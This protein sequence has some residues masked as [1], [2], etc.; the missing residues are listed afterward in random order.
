M[1][2]NE[3]RRDKMA[4]IGSIYHGSFSRSENEMYNYH[5]RLILKAYVNKI[6]NNNDIKDEDMKVIIR[7]VLN[8][9]DI[10]SLSDKELTNRI[11][12][13]KF[14]SHILVESELNPIVLLD[15]LVA[16][17]DKLKNKFVKS[18]PNF[19]MP[20]NIV[21]SNFKSVL[22]KVKDQQS[23]Y[24]NKLTSISQMNSFSHLEFQS[25][26]YWHFAFEAISYV[27]ISMGSIYLFNK[28]IDGNNNNDDDNDDDHDGALK[29]PQDKRISIYSEEEE[30]KSVSRKRKID[31][32]KLT[33][34]SDEKEE[35]EGEVYNKRKKVD[36]NIIMGI[37]NEYINNNNN[38]D[39]EINAKVEGGGGGDH[40]TL[41]PNNNNNNN[42]N[43][44][45][46]VLVTHDIPVVA[47]V[48]KESRTDVEVDK[49]ENINLYKSGEMMNSNDDEIRIIY[50]TL[51]N[52]DIKTEKDVTENVEIDTI[53]PLAH[54]VVVVGDDDYAGG[55]GEEEEEEKWAYE[56]DIKMENDTAEDV[57]EEEEKENITPVGGY[58]GETDDDD[59][60][61]G[62]GGEAIM[63]ELENLIMTLKDETDVSMKEMVNTTTPPPQSGNQ[64]GVSSGGGGVVDMITVEKED[65][66]MEEEEEEEDDNISE[67]G[68]SSSSSSSGRESNQTPTDIIYP[69]SRLVIDERNDE[70][71]EDILDEGNGYKEKDHDDNDDDFTVKEKS[72]TVDE[73]IID[74]GNRDDDFTKEKDATVD[75][76]FEDGL[77]NV[78]S[79]ARETNTKEADVNNNNERKDM[80]NI[81]TRFWEEYLDTH[82]DIKQR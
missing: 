12:Y 46:N 70:E 16:V 42:N 77:D 23:S 1:D 8:A 48:E 33:W 78:A 68:M 72:A 56:K 74:K 17:L 50:E 80:G 2:E 11:N 54:L 64:E 22:N 28:F 41:Q 44:S 34:M 9:D 26:S 75:G 69:Y 51:G 35:E 6:L 25:T 62:G 18:K 7:D 13:I 40:T 39:D 57:E 58:E 45:S 31:Y 76:V 53:P 43:N 67:D 73:N 47:A 24:L 5:K 27:A 38:K 20:V 30:E 36:N 55:G 14:L 32:S 10:T 19:K 63:A 66:G 15:S 29:D 81:F 60:G 59:E 61:G 21:Y 49:T 65:E 82:I 3:N 4:N 52:E 79:T 71:D 37:H